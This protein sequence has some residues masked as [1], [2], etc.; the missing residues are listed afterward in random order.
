MAAV[1]DV[2]HSA[3]ES[4]STETPCPSDAIV[5]EINIFPRGRES[6]FGTKTI[7]TIRAFAANAALT[8]YGSAHDNPVPP[9]EDLSQAAYITLATETETADEEILDFRTSFSATGV[10]DEDIRPI[11]LREDSPVDVTVI[12]N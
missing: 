8:I 7:D 4:C 10:I 12:W 6:G 1:E 9:T 11:A 3:A 5:G 2:F